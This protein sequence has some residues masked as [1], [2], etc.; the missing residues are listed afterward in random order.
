MGHVVPRVP[1]HAR[2]QQQW[3]YTDEAGEMEDPHRRAE[4]KV[5]SKPPV[6]GPQPR[7]VR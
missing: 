2:R 7:F 3:Q 5:S 6:G 4:Q 1:R